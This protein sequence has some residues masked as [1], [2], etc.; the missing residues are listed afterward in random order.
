[1]S[2]T[3]SYL[4][5]ATPPPHH[6]SPAS[7]STAADSGYVHPLSTPSNNTAHSP[8]SAG[9]FKTH[10]QQRNH[11][12]QQRPPSPRPH[13]YNVPS[14]AGHFTREMRDRQSRGKDPYG[15][16]DEF[17][18][19]GGTRTGGNGNHNTYDSPPGPTRML[20]AGHGEHR[21][22]LEKR[23]RARNFLNDPE[24]MMMRSLETGESTTAVRLHFM[25][26]LVGLDAETRYSKAANSLRPAF[27]SQSAG[28]G[29]RSTSV[30]SGR[31]RPSGWSY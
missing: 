28:R 16:D 18:G 31:Q 24:L 4:T 2:N 3:N 19:G 17:D 25:T 20:G 15:S 29:S 14:S 7:P 8:S 26:Q 10:H 21:E 12:Q 30:A 13:M 27:E 11:R 23:L 6:Y 1:M 22:V 5:G 9:P